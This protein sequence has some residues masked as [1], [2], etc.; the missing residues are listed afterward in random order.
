MNQTERIEEAKR[1]RLETARIEQGDFG[2]KKAVPV[3][4]ERQEPDDDPVDE[5]EEL[6]SQADIDEHN[7]LNPTIDDQVS[8][9]GSS[10]T[11]MSIMEEIQEDRLNGTLQPF[12]EGEPIG[13]LKTWTRGPARMLKTERELYDERQKCLNELRAKNDAAIDAI[14]NRR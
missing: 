3:P 9:G 12:V 2:V 5:G 11:G 8:R 6:L 1:L 13:V 10:L 4:P 14:L 7:F